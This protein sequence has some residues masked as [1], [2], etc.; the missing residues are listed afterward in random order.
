MDDTRV[1]SERRRLHSPFRAALQVRSQSSGSQT[2]TSCHLLLLIQLLAQHEVLILQRPDFRL[3][4]SI[5]GVRHVNGDRRQEHPQ[6]QLERCQLVDKTPTTCSQQHES[7]GHNEKFSRTV[8]L[9]FFS[10]TAHRAQRMQRDSNSESNN[11]HAHDFQSQEDTVLARVTRCGDA[12]A[13]AASRRCHGGTYTTSTVLGTSRVGTSSTQS[14]HSYR[15]SNSA[16]HQT[17]S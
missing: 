10:L 1:Q 5:K 4:V 8:S 6:H 14:P 13:T 11:K 9:S 12:L 7:L 2:Q 3:T 17:P 16:G 15:G